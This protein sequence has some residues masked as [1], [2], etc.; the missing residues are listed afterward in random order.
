[1]PLLTPPTTGAQPRP[2]NKSK[3]SSDEKHEQPSN[4][5]N[6]WRRQ[7][8]AWLVVHRHGKLAKAALCIPYAIA[9]AW[10]CPS[11]SERRFL[12][13]QWC[14]WTCAP[15]SVVRQIDAILEANP[16]RRMTA[17]TLA[18]HLGVSD[19]ERSFLR[20]WTIGSYDVPK[21]DR[22]ERRKER[23]AL[24]EQAR[25][26][27]RGAKPR[28]QAFT[29]TKPWEAAGFRSRRTWE[30][31]GKPLPQMPQ[32]RGQSVPQVRGQYTSFL[33]T[34]HEVAAGERN[35]AAQNN[36]HHHRGAKEV[37]AKRRV[38]EQRLSSHHRSSGNKAAL[39]ESKAAKGRRALTHSRGAVK[40][41]HLTAV[42]LEIGQSCTPFPTTESAHRG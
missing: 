38:A 41:H 32:V 28:E 40:V 21:A 26:S 2:T 31:H 34:G 29:K 10:H 14:R 35:A 12:M 19:D 24:A 15:H 20:I 4:D 18:K 3:T 30:R 27:A 39:E 9:A 37:A 25:R 36:G 13:V 6:Y 23:K 17:D 8:I 5:I 16:P 11:D 1:M 7:H 33:V 22:L 42:G